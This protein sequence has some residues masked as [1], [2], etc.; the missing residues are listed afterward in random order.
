M[1]CT[2]DQK[3]KKEVF[4]EIYRRYSTL[5]Y[6]FCYHSLGNYQDANDVTQETF[7]RF[8]Q[9]SED[10]RSFYSLRGLLYKIARNESYIILRKRKQKVEIEEEEFEFY[11]KVNETKEITEVINRAIEKLPYVLREVFVLRFVQGLDYDEISAI[12][13]MNS[14]TLRTRISRAL[15]KMQEFLKPY[16]HENIKEKNK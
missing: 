2:S 9:H 12:T 1:F 8:Y 5:I 15:A 6:N 3:N 13:M 11:D 7:V 16:Y 4:T 14:S 10:F